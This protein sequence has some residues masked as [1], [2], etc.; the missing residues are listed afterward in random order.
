[1]KCNYR[2]KTPRISTEDQ[3]LFDLALHATPA[4]LLLR[5][6][7]DANRRQVYDALDSLGAEARLD[8]MLRETEERGEYDEPN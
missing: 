6:I 2:Y 3:A 5:V 7:T 8:A 4:G 1:M